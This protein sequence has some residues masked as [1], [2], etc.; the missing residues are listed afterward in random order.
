MPSQRFEFFVARRYLMAKR[1]QAVISVI[2]AISVI[3]VAAGVMALVIA[4]AV[5]A[6]FRN[7]LQ[8]NM[9]SATAH[10]T[11]LE[12]Q[13]TI[14]IRDWRETAARLK[15]IPHVV[16]AAPALWGTVMFTGPRSAYGIVKGVPGPESG[17]VPEVLRRLKMGTFEG[18][19]RLDGVPP[20]ILG[21]RLAE[22]AGV[23]VGDR[24]KLLSPEGEMTPAGNRYVDYPFVVTGIFESGFYDLD[25]SFAF[26]SL[27]DVQR[28]MSLGD[29]VNSIELRLD[30][31]YRAAEVAQAATAAAGP[32]RDASTWME[33]HKQVLSALQMERVVTV[34]TIGL[35]QMVAALNIVISLIMMVMEKH[36]DIAILMSMGARRQQVAR[37]FQLQGVLIGAA[38]T[39]IGLIAG[40]TL[41]YLANRG[42]WIRLPEAVYS[43]SFVPFEPRALDGL[44]ISAAAMTVSFLATIYPSRSASRIAPA[45]SLRYE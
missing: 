18:W 30:D 17:S 38:G 31:I 8:R 15:R 35:I 2:T 39:T 22:Q 1:K 42:Q 34:I 11:I 41:S 28:V 9:L 44:W 37:V 43:L 12:K 29:V 27:A 4:L 24:I 45:E 3:G 6:G 21:S 32:G 13:T 5:N 33:Q 7:T 36:R 16:Q 26:A 25:S 10:V 19:K 20:V 23:T 14:G 40:Y